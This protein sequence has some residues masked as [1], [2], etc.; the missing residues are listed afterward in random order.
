MV[1][2][3]DKFAALRT[4]IFT[5]SIESSNEPRWGYFGI[6]GPLA[7]GDNSYAPR[8]VKKVVSEDEEEVTRNI[9]TAP[10]KKG[11]TPDVYF[12]FE[13]PLGLGDPFTDP[14]SAMKKGKMWM[15][16]PDAAFKPPGTVK[17]GINKLGYE[18]VDHC[19]QV[20]DPKAVKEKYAEWTPP[21]N[22]FGGNSKRGGPGVLTG[23]VLFGFGEPG[24]FPEHVPDD[25]DA[26]RKQRK[27]ELEEHH[28]KV[29]EQPF[30]GIDYGNRFFQ[31]N[32]EAFGGYEHPTHVPRDPP[33]DKT[34]KYPHESA[35]RPTN[36]MKRD[37]V[38]CLMGG[39][40]EYI[41]CPE[42][43][44]KR[45]PKDEDAPPAF[46]VGAPRHVVKPTPSVTTLT[47]NMRN[48]RPSSFMR[49]IL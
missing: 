30:K 45:K 24:A 26:A 37:A 6:P 27:K 3:E 14:G 18:Y 43:P 20:K 47:R 34:A 29:Q 33:P 39:I 2:A 32:E 44:L 5:E 7:I 40:P 10:T 36:P 35:F 49:P 23:G 1:E 48:E 42:E 22:I 25:Y 19:D 15:L 8:L 28:S 21:R 17:T 12:K 31:S 11:T 46:K 16:D 38:G 41:P 13:T 9:Q 4:K